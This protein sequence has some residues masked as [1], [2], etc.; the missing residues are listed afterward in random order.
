MKNNIGML[1]RF[2]R[3]ILGPV[4][5]ALGLFWMAGALQVLLILLGVIISATALIGFCPL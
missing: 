1:D 4:L 2:I 3:A 5:V